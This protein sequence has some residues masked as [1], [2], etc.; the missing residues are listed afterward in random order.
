M[1]G[2][3]FGD[4]RGRRLADVEPS[5]REG[6]VEGSSGRADALMWVTMKT[7]EKIL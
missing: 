2:V 3:F 4:V 5:C 6:G 1:H 7:D